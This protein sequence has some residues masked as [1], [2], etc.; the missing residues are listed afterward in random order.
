MRSDSKLS[1]RVDKHGVSIEQ[2]LV[3]NQQ[4]TN[5]HNHYN[6]QNFVAYNEREN[7]E[8][9]ITESFQCIAE[10]FEK[11]SSQ[12]LKILE[13]RHSE[14]NVNFVSYQAAIVDM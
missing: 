1:Q 5:V 9:E 6:F 13:L 14:A 2:Y 8:K 12:A 7:F 11:L 4:L 3:S 10:L